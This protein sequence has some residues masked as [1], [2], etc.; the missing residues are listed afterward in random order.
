MKQSSI[1]DRDLTTITELTALANNGHAPKGCTTK[2]E[3]GSVEGATRTLIHDYD[4][5]GSPRT[6]G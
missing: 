2:V 4:R 6:Y 5:H 1:N 3:V